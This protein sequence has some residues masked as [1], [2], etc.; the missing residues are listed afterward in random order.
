MSFPANEQERQQQCFNV[1]FPDDSE[2]EFTEAVTITIDPSSVDGVEAGSI[3]Q[4]LI[5]ITD[6]DG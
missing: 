5:A 3:P 6:D 1:S 2:Y 4:T